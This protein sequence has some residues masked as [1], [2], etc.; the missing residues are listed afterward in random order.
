MFMPLTCCEIYSPQDAPVASTTLD[1]GSEL[2]P[3]TKHNHTAAQSQ[4]NR[5]SLI[6]S[7][8]RLLLG[9]TTI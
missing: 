3:P 2:A 1:G 8:V 6:I 5:V 7:V 9:A 4:Q